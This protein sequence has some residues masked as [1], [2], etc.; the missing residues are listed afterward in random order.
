MAGPGGVGPKPPSFSTTLQ[1]EPKDDEPI[2]RIRMGWAPW[3]FMTVALLL[4]FKACGV[5]LW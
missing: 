3:L 4:V 2:L 5:T 1:R